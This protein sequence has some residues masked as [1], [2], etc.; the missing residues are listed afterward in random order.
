MI[1]FWITSFVGLQQVVVVDDLFKPNAL[2]QDVVI[3]MSQLEYDVV[4]PI[5]YWYTAYVFW[6]HLLTYVKV[7]FQPFLQAAI[8]DRIEEERGPVVNFNIKTVVN[9]PVNMMIGRLSLGIMG[10]YI[11]D[12]ISLRPVSN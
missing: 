2:M 5:G 10:L 11:L 3:N 12:N 4:F 8:G 1:N 7:R 9:S 6:K